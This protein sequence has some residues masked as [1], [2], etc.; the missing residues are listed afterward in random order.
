[1]MDRIEAILFDMGGTLRGSA[2]RE[3]TEK[4][5]MIGQIQKLIGSIAPVD[6]FTALLD[7]R[8]RV[9]KY[10][11]QETQIELNEGDLW[12]QRMLP[13]WPASQIQPLA[14]QLNQC[15]RQ[16]I[17]S[18]VIFPE[19]KE[20]ALEL[21]RRGYRL[22]LVSNTT[23]SVEV[24][25]ALKEL[26][27][28][29]C[30]ETIVLSAV[31]G[32]RKPDP[33]I[34][35]DAAGRMG[36]EPKYCAYIGDRPDRDVAA[37]RKAGF[38][39]AI[40]LR[41]QIQDLDF[42]ADRSLAPDD[43]IDNLRQLLDLFP[44]RPLAQSRLKPGKNGKGSAGSPM[45]N[46]ISLS[47]MW[48]IGN[49]PALGDFIEMAARLGFAQVEL[50]HQIN[51]AMLAGVDLEH[52]PISSIHEPCPSDIHVDT[53]K[54]RDWLISASD[55]DC[56]KQGVS[57]VKR[58]IELAGSLGVKT[59][60][61]HAG[62]VRSDWPHEKEFYS[63]FKA[64]Q[65]DTR[66]FADL[67]TRLIEE[68][69]AL[70]KPRLTAVQKSL[71][72]LIEFSQPFGVCLG[73]ENRFHYMDIPLP[74][75]MELLLTLADPD[76]LGFW[77]DVGH[78]Q[79]LDRLGFCAS[80]EWLDRFAGRTV[81]VHLHDVIGINDHD[82]PGAGELN[83]DSVIHRIPAEAVFT[84]EVRPGLSPEQVR[85]SLHFLG[86]KAMYIRDNIGLSSDSLQSA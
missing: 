61:V 45:M 54:V 32:K 76:R 21:F 71:A 7:E 1:M 6:E 31:V 48:A 78:A 27:I 69:A 8:A 35:L 23:S 73:L 79:V 55:E 51:S 56:R 40:I 10:W 57:A 75:E 12:T 66:R 67:R 83:F 53:L 38:A 85:N 82:A 20:V 15:Y 29:N 80:Q 84:V 52:A 64:G 63:L 47:T 70:V 43:V 44:P 28:Y 13:D 59:V 4:K 17:G 39:Q 60:V 36:V 74:D 58:S 2:H 5:A 25:A 24:P 30:F 42:G 33:A 86:R 9:Y 62:N 37:S 16:A 68:R 46:K 50:N 14:V 22:G 26:G 81:G 72:E 19:T 3:E 65:A 77:Y 18:R 11:A 49:F 34:L 41:D